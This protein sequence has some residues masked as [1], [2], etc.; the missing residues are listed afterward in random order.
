V[1]RRFVPPNQAPPTLLDKELLRNGLELCQGDVVDS[2]HN[3]LLGQQ[4]VAVQEGLTP[5]D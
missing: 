4:T 5:A 2:V 1:L 3:F